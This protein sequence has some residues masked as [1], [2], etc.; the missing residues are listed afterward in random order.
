MCSV[1]HPLI[2]DKKVA[3]GLH[4]EEKTPPKKKIK[5]EGSPQEKTKFVGNIVSN[6]LQI[7]PLTFFYVDH[8]PE[9]SSN[10]GVAR[11]WEG[12]GQ[13]FFSDLEI[14]MSLC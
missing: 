6:T 10:R 11:I 1:N 12:G 7:A 3:K 4:R 5:F 2:K 8:A 13:Y 9:S 14:C